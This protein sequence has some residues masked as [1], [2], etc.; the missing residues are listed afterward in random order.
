LVNRDFIIN[1]RGIGVHPPL[2]LSAQRINFKAT[3]INSSSLK[4]IYVSNEHV[5]YDQHRHAVPRIGN[6]DIPL[7]GPTYFEFDLPENCPFKL[8]P[9]VGSVPPGQVAFFLIPHSYY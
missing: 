5:D 4:T 1:C 2:K 7:V 9:T 8:S 6:G 3:A